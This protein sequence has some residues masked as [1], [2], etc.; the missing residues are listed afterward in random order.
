M[1]TKVQPPIPTQDESFERYSIRAHQALLESGL[2]PD[3]RSQLVRYAW[4]QH[5]GLTEAE[6]VAQKTF[7]PEKY[8]YVPDVVVFAEHETVDKQGRPRKYGLKELA[9]IVRDNNARVTSRGVFPAIS[10]GH[11]SNPGDAVKRDPEIL[12]WSGPCRL[13]IVDRKKPVWGIL[14]DEYHIKEACPILDRKPR[15]SVELWTFRNGAEMHFDPVAAIGAEAPRLPLPMRYSIGAS[16]ANDEQDAPTLDKY[17]VS[18]IEGGEVEKYTYT[19]S[20][21]KY[22]AVGGGAATSFGAATSSGG[23]AYPGA[24]S[25]NLKKWDGGKAKGK[26]TKYAETPVTGANSMGGT[27]TQQIARE[28]VSFLA[29]TPEFQWVREQMQSMANEPAPGNE[30]IDEL[31]AASPGEPGAGDATPSAPGPGAAPEGQANPDDDLSDIIDKVGADGGEPEASETEEPEEEEGGEGQPSPFPPKKTPEEKDSMAAYTQKEIDG[32]VEKYS[33]LQ[34]SHDALMAD[35]MR[36]IARLEAV[37]KSNAELTKSRSDAFRRMKVR[38]LAEKYELNADEET[39]KWCYSSNAQAG[40]DNAFEQFC[41]FVEKY[42]AKHVVN[43][44]LP[45]GT[46][47]ATET[48]NGEVEKFEAALRPELMKVHGEYVASGKDTNYAEER[49]IAIER[50]RARQGK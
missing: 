32:I 30:G 26:P 45:N 48:D 36:D 21:E 9:Q 25:T 49:S 11:T 14:T 41:G 46:A 40:D 43:H 1:T 47:M 23:F 20:V 13:G 35:R 33:A 10:D 37:E 44:D 12:G 6:E 2:E 31:A 42:A 16:V 50:L 17:S 3:E 15:R 27:D 4:H 34:A 29:Q 8:R 18:Q 28:V 24:G 39:Q 22:D 38:E 19:S 7:D 5:R